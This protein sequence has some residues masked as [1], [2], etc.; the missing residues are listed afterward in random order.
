[1]GDG[2]TDALDANGSLIINGGTI[3]ITAQFAFDYD[4]SAELN[5]GTVTVNEE[6]VTAITETCRW[7]AA[8]RWAAMILLVTAV[9]VSVS[10]K[11]HRKYR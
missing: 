1:M 5:G 3:D 7:E 9:P 11:L 2:D 4:T 10:K 8:A 6:Q